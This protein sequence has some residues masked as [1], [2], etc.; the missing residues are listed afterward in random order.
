MRLWLTPI[1]CER[2]PFILSRPA[3]ASC[4][5][6]DGRRISFVFVRACAV[7]FAYALFDSFLACASYMLMLADFAASS[8]S[9]EGLSFILSCGVRWRPTALHTRT[10]A[11]LQEDPA[12]AERHR[13]RAGLS[14]RFRL[15]RSEC[16]GND[17]HS[18]R[19]LSPPLARRHRS[20][21]KNGPTPRG[22]SGQTTQQKGTLAA[23]VIVLPQLQQPPV[24][25]PAT[26]LH[27]PRRRGRRSGV[28]AIG[29]NEC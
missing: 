24:L 20:E 7:R 5:S 2:R 4:C 25:H 18:A 10:H 17:R 12:S 6:A 21:G 26:D 19:S 11:Q 3:H 14:A 1:K 28:D 15:G 13:R 29:R 9:R 16:R 23:D 27:R 22:R 8:R